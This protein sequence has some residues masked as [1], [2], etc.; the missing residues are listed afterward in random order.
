M[1]HP[2]SLTH[3]EMIFQKWKEYALV[4]LKTL[5]KI[6]EQTTIQV[7]TF[8]YSDCVFAEHIVVWR[9]GLRLCVCKM[10]SEVDS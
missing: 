2:S 3:Q 5:Q 8:I 10:F 9:S 7:C 4:Q 6:M 1:E